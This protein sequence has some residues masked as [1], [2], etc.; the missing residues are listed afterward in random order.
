MKGLCYGHRFVTGAFFIVVKDCC[1]RD[2]N[3]GRNYFL[4]RNAS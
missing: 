2:D 1:R 4:F 3:A